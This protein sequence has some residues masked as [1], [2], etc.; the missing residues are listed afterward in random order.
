MNIIENN[1]IQLEILKNFIAQ[2]K[3]FEKGEEKFWDDPHISMQMLN[4]HL[5]PNVEAASKTI[6]TIQAESSFIINKAKMNYEKTVLDLGCGPGLY[7][8]EF[9]KTEAK[10]T[11]VDLSQRSIDYA[12]NNSCSKL[13]NVTLTQMNYLKMKYENEFDI[14]TL[15]FYDF[16][17][18]NPDEQ[19]ILLYAIYRALKKDG[20][21]ILDVLSENRPVSN[22]T[23]I[24]VLSEGFWSPKPYIE[25]LNSY[26]FE[27]PRTEGIQ[28]SI[29]NEIGDIK[30]YRIYHRLFSIKEIDKLFNSHGFLIKE[31][32]NNLMGDKLTINSKTYGIIAQKK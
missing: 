26:V 23:S 8:K 27:N 1:K 17:A 4:F 19:S 22:S 3:Q 29:I 25:I 12:K 28:Y 31:K 5:N 14:I 16:C 11:G 15:I 2:P 20:L 13:S 9:A 30:N 21:F 32:F 7:I 6:A 10:I 18:L 24:S